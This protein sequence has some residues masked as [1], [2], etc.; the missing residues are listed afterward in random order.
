MARKRMSRSQEYIRDSISRPSEAQ[1]VREE[2]KK[3]R[4]DEILRKNSCG[5][6]E[7]ALSNRRKAK[8][9]R[10]R[11]ISL[12]ILLMILVA[13]GIQGAKI[14]SLIQEKEALIQ[15]QHELIKERT[16]F[17]ELLTN[18][19]STEYVE[20][21]AREQLKLIMPGETL[22]IFPKIREDLDDEAN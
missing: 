11:I 20:Q 8:T 13:A 10:R 7:P 16:K 15:V 1:E 3:W 9:T 14:Y 4:E 21:Q 6:E 12:V 17:L 2:R 22:Y 19:N 5:V 18:V